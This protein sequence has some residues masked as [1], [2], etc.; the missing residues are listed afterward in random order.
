[1]NKIRLRDISP[2]MAFQAHP[3]STAHKVELVER[4]MAAG[5]QAIEV[6][7]FVHPKLV[8]GLADAEQ[9]FARVKRP[10]GVSLECCIGNVTGLQRAIA[11]GADVAWFLLAT[12]EDFS[13]ANIGRTIDES[14][15]ELARMQEVAA[16]ADIRLGTYLIGAFGGPI[17]LARGPEDARGVAQHLM[18]MGVRDWILADSCGYAAP[19]QIQEMVAFAESLNGSEHLTVQVHDSRGMGLANVA[20]LA[21]LGVRN[22]D[23][24]LAGSGAHPAAPGIR[25]GGVCTEDAVQMLHLMGVH[26]G[27]DLAL[28]LET[29]NWLDDILGGKA[30][31]FT[32]RIGAVPVNAA[33]LAAQQALSGAFRWQSA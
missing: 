17:G 12:D 18:S 31:G 13:K 28:L 8:P 24:S 21:R 29:A 2:R 27:V 1:M 15:A 26:T 19:S 5:L 16:R 20:E 33:E 23:L 7:S 32:R 11:S 14:L 6:S 25:V 30:L 22:I 4:L 3:A 10:P 9:V